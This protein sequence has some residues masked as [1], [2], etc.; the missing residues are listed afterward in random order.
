[1]DKTGLLRLINDV[2]NEIVNAV[3]KELKN[4]VPDLTN[5]E[6][7]TKDLIRCEEETG[8]ICICYR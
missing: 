5:K 4:M 8:K 7:L 6:S 2:P 1:M 3:H